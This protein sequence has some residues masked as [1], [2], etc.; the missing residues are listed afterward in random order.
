MGPTWL[1]A[2]SE[3]GQGQEQ[4]SL[5]GTFLYPS[6]DPILGLS[7]ALPMMRS[8]GQIR[9]CF[10]EKL[11]KSSFLYPETTDCLTFS[12]MKTVHPSSNA[13]STRGH[14]SQLCLLGRNSAQLQLPSPSSVLSTLHGLEIG[15]WTQETQNQPTIITSVNPA[16]DNLPLEF[17]IYHNWVSAEIFN[18]ML[19]TS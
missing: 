4:T 7:Q 15:K 14:H 6:E 17:R 19:F 1:D 10:P 5:V 9:V 2:F 12:V 11:Q 13:R 3:L 16:V 8:A 18:T